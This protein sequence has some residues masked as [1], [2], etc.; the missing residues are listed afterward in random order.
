MLTTEKI[1]SSDSVSC[2]LSWPPV[3]NVVQDDLELLSYFYLQ[4]AGSTGDQT[5]SILPVRYL[6]SCNMAIPLQI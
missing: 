4:S 1:Y 3:H 6:L 5:Q 2:S